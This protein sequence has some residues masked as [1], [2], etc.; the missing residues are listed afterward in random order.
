MI[1]DIILNGYIIVDP[2]TGLYSK[3]GI[4]GGC[5]SKK[6]K[7]WNTIS[8]LSNHL[9]QFINSDGSVITLRRFPYKGNELVYEVLSKQSC[10]SVQEKINSLIVNRYKNKIKEY[11][12][13]S[14]NHSIT[15]TYANK[16]DELEKNMKTFQNKIK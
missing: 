12:N 9:V 10:F 2:D 5:N 13:W 4:Y 8:A 7:I 14:E 15:N 11:R 16:A 6:P 3:G 1:N